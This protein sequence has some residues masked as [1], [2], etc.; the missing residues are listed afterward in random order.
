M[1]IC[2][3]SGSA[4]RARARSM[5]SDRLQDDCKM[6]HT[7]ST[8]SVGATHPAASEPEPLPAVS[9]SAIQRFTIGGM[10]AMNECSMESAQCIRIALFR[11]FIS[12]PPNS[13]AA[14]AEC[15]EWTHNRGRAQEGALECTHVR[16]VCNEKTFGTSFYTSV[17]IIMPRAKIN[18]ALVGVISCDMD[19]VAIPRTHA[20]CAGSLGSETLANSARTQGIHIM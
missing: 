6:I 1:T 5:R 17:C 19:I 10:L 2:E 9:A 12:R 7:D 20:S 15:G 13:K 14:R 4:R 3:P 18:N 11:E 8:D 16:V